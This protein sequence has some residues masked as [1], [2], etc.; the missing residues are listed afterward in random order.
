MAA[1]SLR[2]FPR[3]KGRLAAPHMHASRLVCSGRT[4]PAVLCGSLRSSDARAAS[5]RS[6]WASSRTR[7]SPPRSPTSFSSG[8]S[9]TSPAGPAPLTPVL[10]AHLCSHA[11]DVHTCVFRCVCYAHVCSLAR[12]V[13]TRVCMTARGARGSVQQR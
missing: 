3:R 1:W 4:L 10:S 13:R 5:R 8:L 11:R 2:A 6:S 12:A 7:T 9:S